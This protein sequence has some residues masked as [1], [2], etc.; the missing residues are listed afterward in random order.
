MSLMTQSLPE[1]ICNLLKDLHKK[2]SCLMCSCTNTGNT[3]IIQHTFDRKSTFIRQTESCIFS[4]FYHF[5]YESVS[6]NVLRFAVFIILLFRFSVKQ[7]FYVFSV[8]NTTNSIW[9]K[10]QPQYI[11]CATKSCQSVIIHLPEF[12]SQA[13]IV[14]KI[15]ETLS[16][17]LIGDN[18]FKAF[19]QSHM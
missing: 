2:S 19:Q 1:T 7:I 6:R 15:A 13:S 17:R 8:Q 4:S 3:K 10:L 18:A 14:V 5:S 11:V 12:Y 16:Y 9:S